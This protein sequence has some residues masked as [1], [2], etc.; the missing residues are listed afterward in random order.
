ME[1]NTNEKIRFNWVMLALTAVVAFIAGLIIYAIHNLMF[2]LDVPGVIIIGLCAALFV[3]VIG[4]IVFLLSVLF[5]YFRANITTGNK[6]DKGTIF[7]FLLA[8]VVGSGIVMAGLEFIYELDISVGSGDLSASTYVFVVDDSGS[9]YTNDPQN[10]RYTAIQSILENESSDTQ[11]AVYAYGGNVINTQALTTVGAG[12]PALSPSIEIDGGSTNTKLVLETVR[13]D[14]K[15]KLL[16]TGGS[17]AVMLLTDGYAN[18][19]PLVAFDQDLDPLLQEFN[20]MGI[21]VHC[22]GFGSPNMEQLEYIAAETGGQAK[23]V[24]QMGHL[25]NSIDTVLTGGSRTLLTQRQWPSIIHVIMR[26]FFITLFSLMVGLASMFCYG[27]SLSC[28]PIL[29]G[30]AIAGFLAGLLLELGLQIFGTSYFVAAVGFLLLGLLTALI[31]PPSYVE[32]EK[33]ENR[34]VGD[35]RRRERD[36]SDPFGFGEE[37]N[38]KSS[39]RRD[40][41]S[42]STRSDMDDFFGDSS[43]SSRG[44]S[45]KKGNSRAAD[46]DDDI[47]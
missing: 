18:D 47:F 36:T 43:S 21:T 45:K 28:K 44:K 7:L 8:I 46:F 12:V 27:C 16:P 40:P 17:P 39:N 31:V 23:M 20:S 33:Q 25:R 38:N 2:A 29:I 22:I 37:P 3:L 10:Q 6:R 1:N 4:L 9:M 11:F 19:I 24:Q 41:F 13:D 32:P 34:S 15:S 35:G 42:S 30:S 5:G 14:F 26:V